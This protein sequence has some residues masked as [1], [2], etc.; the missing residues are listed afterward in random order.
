MAQ[1]RVIG[2][3]GGIPWHIADEFR[4]FKR[5]TTGHTVLMGRKT[6]DSIGRP[7]PNRRNIVVTRGEAIPGVETIATLD[8]FDPAQYAAPG[9]DVF[10]LGGAQ[11]YALL[12]PK[13]AELLLT[14]IPR[15]VEGDAFFPPFEEHFTFQ[16]IVL[17]HP[18][19]EVH[20]YTAKA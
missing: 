9:T 7:L 6:Y 11:I 14:V 3:D 19:F 2:K 13:C 12:L 8:G 10:V 15:D 17:T 4:W 18:E 5:A 16:E 20:R 1:N